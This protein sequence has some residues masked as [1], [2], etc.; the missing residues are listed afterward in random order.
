MLGKQAR[1][2]PRKKKKK[3]SRASSESVFQ[4]TN[5]RGQKLGKRET[6]VET[7]WSRREGSASSRVSALAKRGTR[8]VGEEKR[9]ALQSRAAV[10]TRGIDLVKGT[11]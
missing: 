11:L 6:P 8:D 1:A 5:V 2:Q 9:G 4:H 10:H 7:G 3:G